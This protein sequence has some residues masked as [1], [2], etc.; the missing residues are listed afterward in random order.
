MPDIEL[1]LA[2]IVQTTNSWLL[3][4][5]YVPSIP[6]DVLRKISISGTDISSRRGHPGQ[7]HRVQRHFRTRELKMEETLE[8]FWLHRERVRGCVGLSFPHNW[9]DDGGAI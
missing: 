3:S 9:T 7:R 5:W 2:S 8:N 1:D 4:D 6:L